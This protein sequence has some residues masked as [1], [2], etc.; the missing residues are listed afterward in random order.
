MDKR[1]AFFE[2]FEKHLEERR[3]SLATV[4][5]FEKGGPLTVQKFY[6]GCKQP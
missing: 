1:Q 3:V 2:F 5:R 6:T 4:S